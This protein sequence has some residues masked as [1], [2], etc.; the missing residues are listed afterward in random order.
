M[1][2]RR[3]RRG[4]SRPGTQCT[5]LRLG[6]CSHLG[7]TCYHRANKCCACRW[8]TCWLDSCPSRVPSSPPPTNWTDQHNRHQNRHGFFCQCF[9]NPHPNTCANDSMQLVAGTIR[10]RYERWQIAYNRASLQFLRRANHHDWDCKPRDRHLRIRRG[11]QHRSLHIHGHCDKS[12]RDTPEH[13]SG[14]R[15]RRVLQT[16]TLP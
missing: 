2:S 11:S 14:K 8:R 4:T 16:R 12:G 7:H 13:R 1:P 3:Q 10:S 5:G 6:R 15:F 9:F